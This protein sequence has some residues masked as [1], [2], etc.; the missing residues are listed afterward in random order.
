MHKCVTRCLKGRFMFTSINQVCYHT[1]GVQDT[2][3]PTHLAT[4][5]ARLQIVEGHL[6][7]A[8]SE[9]VPTAI[10]DVRQVRQSA[11]AVRHINAAR[12]KMSNLALWISPLR[13]SLKRPGKFVVYRDSARTPRNPPFF[14]EVH[15]IIREGS[16]RAD[17]SPFAPNY[18][19]KD[20][21]FSRSPTS[22][23]PGSSGICAS[24][25]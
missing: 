12:L 11:R 2:L 23:S 16:W 18:T 21:Q 13:N 15:R 1:C 4:L 6:H 7:P 22:R 5:E 14:D 8:I 25:L 9:T 10:N 17:L 20:T 19:D 3:A 24:S